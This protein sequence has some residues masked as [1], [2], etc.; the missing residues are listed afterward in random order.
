MADDL[1]CPVHAEV[2]ADL[3]RIK[4]KQDTRPCQDHGARIAS[5]EKANS[6]QWEAIDNLRGSVD[7]LKKIVY[8]GAGATAVLA[9][10]GSIIGAILKR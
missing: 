4:S 1:F 9:F 6:S 7:S 5:A 10:L 2:Q 3:T 8:M